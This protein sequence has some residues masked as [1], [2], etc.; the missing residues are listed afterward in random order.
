MLS[1][2]A[3]E[4]KERIISIIQ[5]RGPSLP[6]HIAKETGLSILFASAFLSELFSEKKI[7]ISD[8]KVGSSPL[9]FIPGQEA[10][11]EN[12]SQY[13]KSKEKDAFILLKEKKILN[14]KEQ[15]P[16]IRVALREIKDFAIPFKKENGEL[17][18]RYF[19][20]SEPKE[21][22][23][24][25]ELKKQEILEKE[26][27]K[28]KPLPKEQKTEVSD[29]SIPKKK[30]VRQKKLKKSKKQNDKFFN[31]IRDF[32]LKR[33]I[34][35]LSVEEFG[36]N[37]LTL[38]VREQEKEYLIIAYNKKKINEMNIIK[39]YKKSLEKNFP[40]KIISLGEPSKKINSLMDALKNLKD[41]EKMD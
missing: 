27:T 11:L 22:E 31:K 1:Q 35:I 12:F 26:V 28:T 8:I 29:V 10:F 9:Y 15:E 36:R 40:Y 41:I 7:K 18:W 34:E 30:T 2:K 3:S 21:E 39:S 14:D 24:K 38:R 17:F 23:I 25:P 5:R 33:Q 32:L 6:V 13:L 37:E 20:I 19:I 4:I 16:A